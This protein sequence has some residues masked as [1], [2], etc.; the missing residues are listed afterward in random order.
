MRQWSINQTS[1]D[2]QID[3][4]AW[5]IEV[6]RIIVLFI[7]PRLHGSFNSVPVVYNWMV[8][9]IQVNFLIHL[10]M[11][12]VYLNMLAMAVKSM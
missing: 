10:W 6:T 8:P 3:F 11:K 12:W 2:S 7:K 5:K 1:S 9:E 4:L